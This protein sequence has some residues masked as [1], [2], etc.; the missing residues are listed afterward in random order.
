MWVIPKELS[1]EFI[2]R[3]N[4]ILTLNAKPANNREPVICFDE[5]PVM[6]HDELRQPIP[7]RPGHPLKRDFEYK[8]NGSAVLH[9][10][11]LPKQGQRLVMVTKRRTKR[12]F[13]FFMRRLWKKFHHCQVIHLIMDNLNTHREKSLID[14]FGQTLGHKIWRKFKIHYTPVHASWLNMAELEL[15]ALSRI[16][17]GKSRIPDLYSLKKRI[18]PGVKYRNRHSIKIS[19]TFTKRDAKRVFKL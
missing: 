1:P 5:K 11:V 6:L 7:A 18:V 16:C 10:A 9:V 2:R 19:W 8:R 15:S 12:E 14:T 13:S 4:D 3:M 17:L